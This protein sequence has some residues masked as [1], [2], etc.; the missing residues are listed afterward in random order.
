MAGGKAIQVLQEE[1]WWISE[2]YDGKWLFYKN[3][4]YGGDLWKLSLEN[5]EKQLVLRNI[6]DSCWFPVKDG[7]YYIKES[8]DGSESNLL[9][10]SFAS[11]NTKKIAILKHK[12]IFDLDIS[13]DRSSFLISNQE[14]GER[15]IYLVENFR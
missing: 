2:S 11:N 5:R 13:A 4:F 15:D 7:I 1:G 6:E 10:F 12:G 9:F 3:Q 8:S 14:I